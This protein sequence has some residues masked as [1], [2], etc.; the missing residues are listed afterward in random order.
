M[1]LMLVTEDIF[2]MEMRTPDSIKTP[3]FMRD[4]ESTRVTVLLR[5]PEEV[6]HEVYPEWIMRVLSENMFESVFF[7]IR[8]CTV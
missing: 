4:Q 8:K 5:V 2:P 3:E 1:A 7:I 6:S